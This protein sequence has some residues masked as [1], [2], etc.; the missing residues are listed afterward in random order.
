MAILDMDWVMRETRVFKSA[1]KS[2]WDALFARHQQERED[3]LRWEAKTTLER[4][5]SM[6]TVR[7]KLDTAR[8]TTPDPAPTPSSVKEAEFD[9]TSQRGK[10]KA[11]ALNNP[12]D[13]SDDVRRCGI[14]WGWG[15]LRDISNVIR[16]LR[17]R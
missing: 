9:N 16:R 3:L 5:S 1:P 13:S 7:G 11:S 6:T 10:K 2:V 4:T 15:I 17:C 14:L 12:L 8:S